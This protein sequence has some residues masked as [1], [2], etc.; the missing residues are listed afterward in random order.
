MMFGFGKALDVMRAGDAVR[1][2]SWDS[3][4]ALIMVP[5]SRVTV[6]VDRPLGRAL[7]DLA[8]EPLSYSAH[9]DLVDMGVERDEVLVM[10]ASLDSA[11]LLA[12][13]WTY[14]REDRT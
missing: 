12:E 3:S 5:A 4:L 8:G 14:A 6:D 13:D 9:L 2:E 11:D 7:P 10:P 1:R